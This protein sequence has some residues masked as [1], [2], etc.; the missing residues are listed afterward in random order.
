MNF[1]FFFNYYCLIGG[2]LEALKRYLIKAYFL[3]QAD[4]VIDITAAA[5]FFQ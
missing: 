4:Q 3:F 5:K 2:I 1:K